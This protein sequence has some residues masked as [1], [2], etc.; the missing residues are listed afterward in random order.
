MIQIESK[1]VNIFMSRIAPKDVFIIEIKIFM[2][3][4]F[5]QNFNIIL[6]QQ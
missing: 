2:K 3:K 4:F 6:G 5:K 1:L